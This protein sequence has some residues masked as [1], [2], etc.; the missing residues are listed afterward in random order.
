[1][2]VIHVYLCTGY[3]IFEVDDYYYVHD[4]QLSFTR[5]EQFAPYHFRSRTRGWHNFNIHI[6]R[7]HGGKVTRRACPKG[8]RRCHF[9]RLGIVCGEDKQY[10]YVQNALRSACNE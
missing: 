3:N 10:V 7:A 2:R 6:L 1:M 9:E 5:Y 4:E 8:Y